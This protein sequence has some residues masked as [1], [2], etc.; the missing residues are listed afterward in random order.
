VVPTTVEAGLALALTSNS[1][2]RNSSTW[3]EWE[4]LSPWSLVKARLACPKFHGLGQVQ[5]EIEAPQAAHRRLAL[6][7][8]VAP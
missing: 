4:E 8:F 3:K 2:R 7:D 6:E 5:L 1:G